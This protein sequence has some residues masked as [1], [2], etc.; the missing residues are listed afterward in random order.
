MVCCV[1]MVCCNMGC[2][3]IMGCYRG[4]QY[5]MFACWSQLGIFCVCPLAQMSMPFMPR[6]DGAM[7]RSE[8]FGLPPVFTWVVAFV[9]CPTYCAVHSLLLCQ[10]SC[11]WVQQYF[12]V[13]LLLKLLGRFLRRNLLGLLVLHVGW[14]PPQFLL[15]LPRPLRPFFV[16]GVILVLLWGLLLPMLPRLFRAHRQLLLHLAHHH[17]LFLNLGLMVADGL[18]GARVTARKFF[19]ERL[20]LRVACWLVLN[21]VSGVGSVVLAAAHLYRDCASF[22]SSGR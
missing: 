17:R 5:P 6:V 18:L 20:V 13:L 8:F 14:F 4:M 21:L 11:P 3:V 7:L 12:A 22:P 15:V 2:C 19:Y 1:I 9:L 16:S 10:V